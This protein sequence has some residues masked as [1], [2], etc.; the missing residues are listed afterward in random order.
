MLVQISNS[1][2]P[3]S[4]NLA[5]P[6]WIRVTLPT[7][8]KF[9]QLKKMLRKANLHTVCEEAACPNIYECFSKNVATF[10]IMGDTC[11]RY[12]HYCHVKT[13]KPN[14][15]DETE[16][17]NIAKSVNQLGL[18]YVV[19]TSVTRDDLKDGGA[20]HF[21]HVVKAIHKETECDVEVLTQ[22]FKYKREHVK[23]VVDAKP[24]VFAHNIETVE[25]IYKKVRP[26]GNF[27][28]SLH[29]INIIKEID[30][31]MSTKSGFMLGLG[32]TNEEVITLMKQLRK[33]DCDF[34]C[35]GQYLQPTKKH[36]KVEKFYT[37]EE[38]KKF[39][40]IGYKLGFKHVE[41]GPLVRSSYRADKLQKKL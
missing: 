32:E 7:Q 8:E 38:F 25:R 14:K 22:D 27:H 13:G 6:D 34:L 18:K 36:A 31:N 10:M 3:N 12:C 37:P 17:Q 9:F 29:L 2:Q 4:S 19:I 21:A 11:T 28:K 26:K 40:K 15:L 1:S 23:I 35:I 39:E 33:V 5:K 20:Q 16:P 24:Q 30:E 41:A